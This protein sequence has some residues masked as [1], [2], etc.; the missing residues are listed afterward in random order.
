MQQCVSARAIFEE[1][2]SKDAIL[3]TLSLEGAIRLALGERDQALACS[4]T[5]VR[6]LESGE[7]CQVPEAIYFN[8]Y[9]IL[10]AHD[11]HEDARKYL[12]KAYAELMRRAK[13][14]KNP[15]WRESFLK[16]VKTHREILAAWEQAQSKEQWRSGR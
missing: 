5:A 11:R 4:T 15:D 14:I 3:E 13:C 2:V 10:L 8:H 9:K 6:M 7:S 1:L 16:N 12:Q